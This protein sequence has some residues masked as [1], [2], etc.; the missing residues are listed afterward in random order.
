[1]ENLNINNNESESSDSEDIL[2]LVSIENINE[3]T[4]IGAESF[5]KRT[6]EQLK[7]PI[8][9]SSRKDIKTSFDNA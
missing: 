5:L 6:F 3:K 8:D 2:D 7:R 9:F 4:S 1:M